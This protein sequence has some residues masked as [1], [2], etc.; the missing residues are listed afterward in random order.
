MYPAT[1]SSQNSSRYVPT[2]AQV[3]ALLDVCAE[4]HRTIS[5][6]I[7]RLICLPDPISSMTLQRWEHLL[8]EVLRP[9]LEARAIVK[10]LPH[11][12]LGQGIALRQAYR[13][14]G[15][16]VDHVKEVHHTP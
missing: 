14:S 16:V 11:E 1:A 4:A 7:N 5:D 3:A 9:A 2:P 8:N 15:N 12:L 10:R 13:K 6:E